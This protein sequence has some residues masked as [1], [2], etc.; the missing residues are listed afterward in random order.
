[1]TGAGPAELRTAFRRLYLALTFHYKIR[2]QAGS[3]LRLEIYC[4]QGY[5]VCQIDD[6]GREESQGSSSIPFPEQ[7][8]RL[9]QSEPRLTRVE[10]AWRL[11]ER[12]RV[13]DDPQE[14]AA[15][16]ERAR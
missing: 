5:G 3:P 8:K 16:G 14:S 4:K 2:C 13:D 1:V 9:R 7:L 12:P 11:T 10:L 15:R 6:D